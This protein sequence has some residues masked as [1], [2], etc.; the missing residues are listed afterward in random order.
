MPRDSSMDVT[1]MRKH[2]QNFVCMRKHIN[3]TPVVGNISTL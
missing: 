1:R 3:E 2:I